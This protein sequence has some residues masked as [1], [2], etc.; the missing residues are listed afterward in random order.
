M[1]IITLRRTS[2]LVRDLVEEGYN[3]VSTAIFRSDPSEK[4]FSKYRQMRGGS[5]REVKNS[6]LILKI[7]RVLKENIN[8][9][10]EKCTYTIIPVNL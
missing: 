8:F 4:H 1:V 2:S 7:S 6:E 9:W 5:L 3:Y 10:D